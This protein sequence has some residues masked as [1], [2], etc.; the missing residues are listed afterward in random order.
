VSVCPLDCFYEGEQMIVTHPDE[1]I[2]CRHY[3]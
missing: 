1:C 3:R 2:D